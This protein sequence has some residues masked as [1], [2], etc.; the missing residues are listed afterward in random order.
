M[1]ALL[2][3][4][5]LDGDDGEGSGI[6]MGM[7]IGGSGGTSRRTEG[8]MSEDDLTAVVN[9]IFTFAFVWSFGCNIHDSSRTKF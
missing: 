1:A 3:S 7:G 8:A 9:Q 5:D 6:G 2:L 4:D